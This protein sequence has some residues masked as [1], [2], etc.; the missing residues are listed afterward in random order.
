M[1]SDPVRPVLAGVDDSPMSAAVASLAAREA[2][3]RGVPAVLVHA[4]GAGP[5]PVNVALVK[6]RAAY[7]ESTVIGKLVDGDPA[8]ALM[9]RS[10]GAAMVVSGTVAAVPDGHA[11][12]R[13]SRSRC[14]CS[15]VPEHR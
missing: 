13:A 12:L 8:A 9:N 3:V 10:V 14:G 15:A 5:G 4:A 1:P 6:T 7:P 11:G 2:A